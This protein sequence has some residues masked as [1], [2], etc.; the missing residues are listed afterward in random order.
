MV[1]RCA[2][3]RCARRV[4]HLATACFRCVVT[5]NDIGVVRR[6]NFLFRGNRRVI[7]SRGSA[8]LLLRRFIRFIFLLVN[9]KVRWFRS[10]GS[11][12]VVF[13]SFDQIIYIRSVLRGGRI[14]F[15]VDTGL[16]SY[17]HVFWAICLRPISSHA[18]WYYFSKLRNIT[19]T[20]LRLDNVMNTRVGIN[21]DGTIPYMG[22]LFTW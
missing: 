17:F 21:E 8:S 4:V 11:V 9:I 22:R 3:R 15:G 10:R 18:I 13:F 7:T 2:I 14:C 16:T 5:W 19:K 6:I 1:N 20:F 12:F